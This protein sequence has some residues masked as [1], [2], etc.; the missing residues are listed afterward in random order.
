YHQHS[1]YLMPERGDL[2]LGSRSK[3]RLV[4]AAAATIVADF[5]AGQEAPSTEALAER[6]HIPI[7]AIELVLVPLEANGILVQTGDEPPGWM[8]KRPPETILVTDLL[9]I[10]RTEGESAV[11][12]GARLTAHTGVDHAIAQFDAAME[13]ALGG[14]TLK[15]IAE[16]GATPTELPEQPHAT[17]DRPQGGR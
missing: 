5:H 7:T 2:H 14:S 8:P 4:L 9:E 11:M 13:K 17:P 3:E 15:D 1:E 6:L 10:I 16:F 12:S